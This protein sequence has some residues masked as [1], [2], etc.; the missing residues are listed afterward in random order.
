MKEQTKSIRKILKSL[1]NLNAKRYWLDE[2]HIASPYCPKKIQFVKTYAV[3]IEVTIVKYEDSTHKMYRLKETSEN[4]KRA[5][6]LL[7]A[8][9]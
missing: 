1:L 7:K 8:L 2:W 6:A 4:M 3:I 9:S 5:K